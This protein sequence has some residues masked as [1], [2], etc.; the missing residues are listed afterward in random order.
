MRKNTRGKRYNIFTKT[1][2]KSLKIVIIHFSKVSLECLY[3]HT[4]KI[5]F[6]RNDLKLQND[7]P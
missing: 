3:M 6:K 2:Y 4:S 5:L 7:F 1:D